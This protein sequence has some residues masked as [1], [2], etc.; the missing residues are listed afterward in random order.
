MTIIDHN[1]PKFTIID[2]NQP[3]NHNNWKKYEITSHQIIDLII[4]LKTNFGHTID[5]TIALKKIVVAQLIWQLPW[6]FFGK[7]ID[8]TI[9][10]I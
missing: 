5:L 4:E 10:L 6:I 7:I 1:W 3:K 2:Q 9:A 8:L